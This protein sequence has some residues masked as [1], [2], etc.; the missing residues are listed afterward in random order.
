LAASPL[1]GQTA[2]VIA[3]SPEDA[4][5]AKALFTQK[6]EIE[7]K[8]KHLEDAVHDKYLITPHHGPSG[9]YGTYKEGW[10]AGFDYSED[11]KFIVPKVYVPSSTNCCGSSYGIWS[12]G[13]NYTTITPATTLNN[14][15]L[16]LAN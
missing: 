1:F 6:A 2:K 14:G 13:C 3:L 10:S 11:F 4:A 8:I 7:K 9:L 12:S 16:I 5:Q 15:N